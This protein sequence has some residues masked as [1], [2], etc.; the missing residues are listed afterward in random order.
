MVALQVK[1]KHYDAVYV[2]LL[3]YNYIGLYLYAACC[4]WMNEIF[5]TYRI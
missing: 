5:R 3:F 1:E 2:S 4:F